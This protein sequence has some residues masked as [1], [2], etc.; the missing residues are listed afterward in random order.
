MYLEQLVWLKTDIDKYKYSRHGFGLDRKKNVSAGNGFGK[1]CIIFGVGMRSSGHADNLK[2]DF[3]VLGEGPTEQL[4]G[5]IL[6]AEKK[7]SINFTENIKKLCLRLHC[8]GANSYLFINGTEIIKFNGKH[9]EIAAN[10]LCLENVSKEFS[11]DSMEK[12]GLNGYVY[13]FSA[14]YDAI[15]VNDILGIH[16]YLIK[17]NGVI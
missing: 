7:Y 12:T 9:S 3:L 2:K 4:D 15:A 13:D 5:T 14:D 17:K 10:P 1:N 16:K 6:I 11:V 8:N